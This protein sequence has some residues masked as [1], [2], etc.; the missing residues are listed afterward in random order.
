MSHLL[1]EQSEL[2]PVT[3][4]RPHPQNPRQGDVGAICLSIRANGF[5]G[6]LVCQRSTRYILVGNHRWQSAV[7]EGLTHVPVFWA[8]VDDTLAVKILLADNRTSELA[9]WDEPA[10]LAMLT[11]LDQTPA[12]LDGTGY[13]GDALDDLV[14][15]QAPITI[16]DSMYQPK[17]ETAA[18]ALKEK[19]STAPGQLWLI[20][21]LSQPGQAH[22]V[23][24]GDAANPDPLLLEGVNIDGICTDPPYEM[25]AEQVCAIADN[26]GVVM[27][28]LMSDTQ[29][30]EFAKHW[31]F[32][33]MVVWH[34]RTPRLN[35]NPTLP[36]INHALCPIYSKHPRD[37]QSIH[38]QKPESAYSTYFEVETEYASSEHGHGKASAV[39]EYMMGPFAWKHVADPFLGSGAVLLACE[40]QR[41]LCYGVELDPARA[42]I[43]LD[44]IESS[45]LTPILHD[46]NLIAKREAPHSETKKEFFARE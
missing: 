13:D 10:L 15:A 25:P 16:L 26:F 33:M 14:R 38:F 34:H 43:A 28:A 35:I 27:S 37:K 1:A 44:R 45:G 7:A 42:A 11:A 8:D 29:A 18:N 19:W 41:R 40:A 36:V 5:W 12:G 4:I 22:R 2:V 20:P 6:G 24:I 46:D 32:R 17:D 3:S 21:S 39:F 31:N 30:M 23:L 9:T